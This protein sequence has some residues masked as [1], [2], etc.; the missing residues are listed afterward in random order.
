LSATR[1]IGKNTR[2]RHQREKGSG[3]NKSRQQRRKV[4][5]H[6]LRNL[7][8]NQKNEEKSIPSSSMDGM[9]HRLIRYVLDVNKGDLHGDLGPGKRNLNGLVC[10]MLIIPRSFT[11]RARSAAILNAAVI[12]QLKCTVSQI[13][14]H[15]AKRV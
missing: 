15:A 7:S 5:G 14:C 8:A 9:R 1:P 2:G 4:V 11:E 12:Y 13:T 6:G 10:G 3:K